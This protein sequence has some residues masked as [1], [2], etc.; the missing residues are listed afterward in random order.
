MLLANWWRRNHGVDPAAWLRGTYRT[1]DEKDA[2]LQQH[3]G[4]Q[5]LVTR[6]AVEAGAA[7]TRNPT[8]G[9][10]G[11]VALG[12]KP[13]GAICTGRVAGKTCWAA[14]SETGL[15]FLTNPRILRAW[16]INDVGQ[17]G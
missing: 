16:S 4:L 15:T 12:G 5:R 1:A 6:I 13:Y 11:L 3:R 14:R 9:D 17:L 10:I 2:V 7:R 8:T